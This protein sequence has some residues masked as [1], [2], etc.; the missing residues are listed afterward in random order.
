MSSSTLKIAST[1]KLATGHQMPV[2][3]LGVY[4]NYTTKQSCLEAFKVG[5]RLVDTAQAYRSEAH[6]G[7]AVRE[8][9]LKREEV[10][11]TT[12]CIS[13][14]HGYESTLRNVDLSLERFGFMYID[15]FLIH[16]PF[17]GP[18]KRLA[19]YRALQDAKRAG[20]IREVG[21]SN[22]GIHHLE[23]VRTAGF[24][25]PA[26]NQIELHPFCQQKAIVEYCRAHSII[27]QAYSP[28]ICGHM[29]HPV[30]HAVAQRHKR[31]VAQI[32]IRWS[33]QKGFVPLPKSAQAHRI[34]SNLDVFDFELTTQE[35]E[36]LDKLDR[37]KEGAVTWNPVDVP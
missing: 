25:M 15:L 8:S 19:T 4:K 27:V 26:V 32:L 1:I 21:V 28:L 2:V 23:E 34:A 17:S 16:D 7:A 29:E 10:F 37:G 9:G 14:T 20:K 13:K 30:L 5:Y 18:E 3:G 36:E 22:Y 6:V 12:K 11:V 35:E 24:D 31:D 33:L